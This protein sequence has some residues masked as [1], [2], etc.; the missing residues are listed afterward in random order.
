[1]YVG[2]LNDFFYKPKD[3]LLQQPKLDIKK[4]KEYININGTIFKFNELTGEMVLCSTIPKT[5]NFRKGQKE[6][7]KLKKFKSNN[8]IHIN[9]TINENP[10]NYFTITDNPLSSPTVNNKKNKDYFNQSPNSVDKEIA[11]NNHTISIEKEVP[12]HN[13]YLKTSYNMK[14]INITP[15]NNIKCL[16]KNKS[17]QSNLYSKYNLSSKSNSKKNF[18]LHHYITNESNK[19]DKTS[20]YFNRNSKKYFKPSIAFG[21]KILKPLSTE[22]NNN[23][24]YK[25]NKNT[26][27]LMYRQHNNN[28]TGEGT[29]NNNIYERKN[30]DDVIFKAYRDQ[31]FK[32]KISNVLKRKYK[33]YDDN[34]NVNLKVPHI[35]HK[36]YNFYRGYS[37]S[38]KRR[39]PIHHKLFFQYIEKYKSKEKEE[40]M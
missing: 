10:K 5:I 18:K 20:L 40:P 19:E 35:T 29:E 38:D 22:K 39:V 12:I 4:N 28:I 14:H 21:Q 6:S 27:Y 3:W 37:F 31:I 2:S 26:L 15:S 11:I 13:K 33:F 25:I 8:N 34:N 16:S 36:N 23:K 9:K 1:M 17:L 24:K 30:D 32:E 7:N